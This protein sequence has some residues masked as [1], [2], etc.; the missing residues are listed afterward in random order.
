MAGTSHMSE[1][2][3]GSVKADRGADAVISTCLSPIAASNVRVYRPRPFSSSSSPGLGLGDARSRQSAVRLPGLRLWWS[4]ER[5]ESVDAP[6]LICHT[7]RS[8]ADQMVAPPVQMP[9]QSVRFG[10]GPARCATFDLSVQPLI[11]LFAHDA[12]DDEPEDHC[13]DD[14]GT[15]HER[16]EKAVRRPAIEVGRIG[17]L[18]IMRP[19]SYSPCRAPSR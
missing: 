18:M 15:R 2:N 13:R 11:D 14:N 3:A 16:C 9:V 5:D 4:I 1:R 10:R 7:I 19:S 12:G 17:N 8:R 6:E